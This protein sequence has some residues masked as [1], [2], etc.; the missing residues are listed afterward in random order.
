ML[1][2]RILRCVST[3]PTDVEARLISFFRWHCAPR[4]F[5]CLLLECVLSFPRL[6]RGDGC[7]TGPF[8]PRV[9]MTSLRLLL[10]V[11]VG[12]TVREAELECSYT[13]LRIRMSSAVGTRKPE[14]EVRLAFPR[15]SLHLFFRFARACVCAGRCCESWSDERGRKSVTGG[16][17][18]EREKRSLKR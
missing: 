1:C 3:Q 18:E 12:M 16:T 9:C 2:F 11:I 8:M 10:R 5:T 7:A 14:M 15:G 13:R 4:R 17:R 6:L